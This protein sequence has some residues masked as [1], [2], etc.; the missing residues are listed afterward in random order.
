MTAYLAT[1]RL[2]SL[3]GRAANRVSVGERAAS[4]A[5]IAAAASDHGSAAD[6]GTPFYNH[7]MSMI[8]ETAQENR[9][10]Q[11]DDDVN[12]ALLGAA[13]R[14]RVGKLL[15]AA[16]GLTV[17]VAVGSAVIDAGLKAMRPVAVAPE[18]GPEKRPLAV[19]STTT[20][21]A[22]APVSV[23]A[24][25][26]ER[27]A[28]IDDKGKTAAEGGIETG[29]IAVKPAD[30]PPIAKPADMP[31]A[32]EKLA[33]PA[34]AV[35]VTASESARE[36]A[37]ETANES[38]KE[39]ATDTAAASHVEAP[40]ATKTALADVAA[41][42]EASPE[43]KAAVEVPPSPAPASKAEPPVAD[44]TPIRMA[45]IKSDVNMRAG[46]SNTQPV[47]ATLARGSAVELLECRAWCEV[48]FRGQ[49]GWVYKGF[50][51]ATETARGR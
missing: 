32:A 17:V 44:T 7:L 36:A 14:W 28:A 6:T 16:A 25:E 2:E 38:A 5:P 51:G 31:P 8:D 19:A 33:V 11:Q 40:I 47:V 9:R 23:P 10:V 48:I 3:A 18:T 39:A 37:K 50:V 21:E 35:K 46:P 30:E 49:R 34:E 41:P 43:E 27:P 20:V 42:I 13:P 24:A 26:P 1:P 4:R 22:P 45:R 29:S 12:G 15:T